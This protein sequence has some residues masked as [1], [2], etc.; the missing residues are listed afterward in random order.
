MSAPLPEAVRVNS[1]VV[2]SYVGKKSPKEVKSLDMCLFPL[3]KETFIIRESVSF[4]GRRPTTV[5]FARVGDI[6]HFQV[7]ITNTG[8]I[9]FGEGGFVN[10]LP[11]GLYLD[12]NSITI[13]GRVPNPPV[14]LNHLLMTPLEV[15]SIL[16]IN[17]SVKVMT[18]GVFKNYSRAFMKYRYGSIYNESNEITINVL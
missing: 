8:D 14:N 9:N 11:E 12:P 2:Y 18:K 3:A 7:I 1:T 5:I 4:I 17:F 16:I 13:N 15:D 6:V 10:F